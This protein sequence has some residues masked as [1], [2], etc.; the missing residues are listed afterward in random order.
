MWNA[1]LIKSLRTMVGSRLKINEPMSRYTSFKIGG[2]AD[3]FVDIE[4]EAELKAILKLIRGGKI[5]YFILGGGTNLLVRDGGISGLTIRPGGSFNCGLRIAECGMRIAECGMQ[6]ENPKSEI[7]NPK[8]EESEIRNPK[9]EIVRVGAGASLPRLSREAA[10]AGL[11]GLEFAAGIP[12][13]VGG[14]VAL[15]AS[16]FGKSIG[17]LVAWVRAAYPEGEEKLILAKDIDFTYRHGLKE[18][19]ILEVGLKLSEG[20]RLEIKRR[21]TELLAMKKAAQPFGERTAG[22]IFL[23]PP[24]NYAGKLIEEAGLKGFRL[25]GAQVSN[26]HANFIQNIGRATAADVLELI[27]IIRARVKDYAGI[28]LELEINIVGQ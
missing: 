12:G 15:N 9:S 7:C 6:N 3:I 14:A 18:G 27:E 1:E 22:C 4:S 23:N 19:I 11:S 16:A 21:T 8:S 25:G 20:N 17:E 10:S 28:D 2:P 26:K 24:G 5:P 13:K